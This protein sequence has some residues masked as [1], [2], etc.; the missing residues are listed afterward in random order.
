MIFPRRPR[1]LF[2]LNATGWALHPSWSVEEE[3]WYAPQGNKSKTPHTQGVVAG[4]PLATPG[5][6]GLA[7]GLGPQGYYQGWRSGVAPSACFVDKTR[8]FFETVQDSFYVHPVWPNLRSSLEET[9]SGKVRQD[10]FYEHL[11]TGQWQ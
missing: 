2:D 1:Q 11:T 4:A 6:D 9:F 7:A 5:T 3:D 10:A 8:L